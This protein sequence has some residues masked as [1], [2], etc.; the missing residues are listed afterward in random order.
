MK[1]ILIITAT[2]LFMATVSYSQNLRN[3]KFNLPVVENEIAFFTI[4]TVRN[5]TKSDFYE[6][7]KDWFNQ[8]FSSVTYK[9]DNTLPNNKAGVLVGIVTFKIDDQNIK[10]PLHYTAKVTVKF[11]NG[12]A[13]VKLHNLAYTTSDGKSKY[14]TDVTNEVK[15]QILAKADELYPNTWNSLKDFANDLLQNFVDFMYDKNMEKL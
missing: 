6:F 15:Q 8:T 1:K 12:I 10:A 7:T 11:I 4:D 3:N 5:L 14:P 9:T 2:L 13:N